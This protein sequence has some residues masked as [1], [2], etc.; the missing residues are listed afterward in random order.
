MYTVALY[1]L[2]WWIH[3]DNTQSASFPKETDDI[4]QHYS[5]TIIYRNDCIHVTIYET[6]QGVVKTGYLEHYAVENKK[7]TKTV[8]PVEYPVGKAGCSETTAGIQQAWAHT[9]GDWKSTANR[10]EE[11]QHILINREDFQGYESIVLSSSDGQ[12]WVMLPDK[13]L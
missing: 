3:S 4:F 5:G 12:I 11:S 7:G 13:A 8:G 6:K 1:R 9:P 2:Y 10:K